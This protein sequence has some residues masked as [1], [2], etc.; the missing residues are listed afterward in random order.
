MSVNKEMSKELVEVLTAIKH[1]HK[2]FEPL[3]I[4]VGSE[5]IAI[6]TIDNNKSY[7]D[8]YRKGLVEG[9]DLRDRQLSK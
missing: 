2:C 4:V 8:N 6:N 3:V 1:K 5:T 9:Y 7:N